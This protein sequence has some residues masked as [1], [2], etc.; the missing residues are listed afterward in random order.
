MTMKILGA[1]DLDVESLTDKMLRIAGE[2]AGLHDGQV[3]LIYVAADMPPDVIMHLPENLLQKLSE[4]LANQ[5]EKLAEGLKLP[6]ESVH[7]VLRHGHV[8]REILAQ[9]EADGTDLIVIGCHK[10]SAA[11][12]LLGGN[13]D[14]VARHA[15]CSVYMVR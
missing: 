1:V 7:A 10:P 5:L 13:A 4:D 11:D 6:S 3:T 2:I 9:A 15:A 12:F 8:Y 14:K